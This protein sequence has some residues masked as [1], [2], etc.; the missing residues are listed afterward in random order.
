MIIKILGITDIFI[1]M[2]FW[3]FGIFNIIPDK[4]ILFLGLFLLIKG[5]I[6]SIKINVTSVLDIL[7]AAV[8]I[9]STMMPMPRF[10]VIIV[11][12][13][14]VQKGIFSLLS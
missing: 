3:I 2:C 12:L 1:A 4:F 10:I 7:S 5:L 8:I 13:F 14:L 6:F 9:L 11:T